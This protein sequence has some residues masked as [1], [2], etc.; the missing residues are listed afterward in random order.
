MTLPLREIVRRFG[1]QQRLADALGVSRQTVKMWCIR[2]EVSA[3]YIVPFCNV[4]GSRP[5]EVSPLAAQVVKLSKS[6][7]RSHKRD[8]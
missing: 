2:G 3:D 1:S 4:V 5:E 6:F 7:R 8:C